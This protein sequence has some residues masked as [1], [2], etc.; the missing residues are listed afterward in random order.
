MRRLIPV[1]VLR[2]A[3]ARQGQHGGVVYTIED[4]GGG[5]LSRRGN[6]DVYVYQGHK[7]ALAMGRK[8]VTL[9]IVRIGR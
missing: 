3:R 2:I 1:L 7:K 9:R 5:G 4:R 8:I 6:L